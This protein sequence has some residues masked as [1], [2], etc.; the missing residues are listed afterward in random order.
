MQIGYRHSCIPIQCPSSVH[1]WHRHVGVQKELPL[2]LINYYY[3][4]FNCF[5]FHSHLLP[6]RFI[7]QVGVSSSILIKA[8]VHHHT[9]L[10]NIGISLGVV[11]YMICWNFLFITAVSGSINQGHP[12]TIG[13]CYLHTAKC[14]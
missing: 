6:N 4:Y 10:I 12:G 11:I 3:L 8:Y 7:L 9:C 13:R 5:T 1:L 2:I 14:Q